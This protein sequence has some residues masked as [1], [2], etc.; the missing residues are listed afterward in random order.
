M[1]E[2]T[3]QQKIIIT[4][5]TGIMAVND[6]SA[7]HADVE[8]RLGRPVWTHQ[9]PD[10]KDEIKEVYQADFLKCCGVKPEESKS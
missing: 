10:L 4:G 7:F 8:K 3:E 9:F 1:T 2:F 5:Y 6:F